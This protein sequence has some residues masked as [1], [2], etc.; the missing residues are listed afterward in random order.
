VLSRS[1]VPRYQTISLDRAAKLTGEAFGFEDTSS[2]EHT[3]PHASFGSRA[4]WLIA[5]LVALGGLVYI[6]LR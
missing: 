3:A 5:G 6:A 4:L 2:P 1:G